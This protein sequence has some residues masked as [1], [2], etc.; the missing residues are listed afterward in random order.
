MQIIGQDRWLSTTQN[1]NLD[2]RTRHHTETEYL[3]RRTGNHTEIKSQL[4][5]SYKYM[6]QFPLHPEPHINTPTF[7]ALHESYPIQTFGRTEDAANCGTRRYSY[8]PPPYCNKPH[9]PLALKYIPLRA[10]QPKQP[11]HKSLGQFPNPEDKQE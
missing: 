11:L 2:R 5:N 4:A 3:A 9:A 6:D 8:P 1:L 10:N 7:G